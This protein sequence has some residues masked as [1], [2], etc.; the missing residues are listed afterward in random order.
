MK[1]I[2][3]LILITALMILSCKEVPTDVNTSPDNNNSSNTGDNN[4]GENNDN[5]STVT[6]EELDKYGI[7]IDSA[8]TEKVKEALNMYY[9]DKN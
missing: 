6:Q 1:K 2:L 8:T 7:D 9:Q 5:I 4:N 3:I